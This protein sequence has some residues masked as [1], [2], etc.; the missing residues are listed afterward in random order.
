MLSLTPRAAALRRTQTSVTWMVDTV[1]YRNISYAPWRPM[2]IRQ[3]LRTNN[4][5]NVGSQFADSQVYIRRI[6][7]T[8]FSAQAVADAL[9]CVSM[10]ACY[11]PMPAPPVA[12]ASTYVS[13]ASSP[14]RGTGRRALLQAPNGAVTALAGAVATVLPG[15]A[16]ENVTATPS[17]FGLTLRLGLKNLV[18][19]NA[20]G[21]ALDMYNTANLQAPMLAGFVDDVTPGPGNM[22]VQSLRSA[23][24]PGLD[25]AASLLV[26]CADMRDVHSASAVRTRRCPSCT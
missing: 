17:A 4:G 20:T 6:R 5:T 21:D 12:V 25:I 19:G 2:S 24:S 1:V 3:I 23:N 22:I 15:I 10:F 11:G 26:F 7:Y 8:P 13:L 16:A 18:S 9:R 14:S